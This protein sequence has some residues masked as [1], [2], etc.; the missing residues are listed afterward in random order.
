MQPFIKLLISVIVVIVF[1][2]LNVWGIQILRFVWSSQIDTK[3]TFWRSMKRFISLPKVSE[4]IVVRDP[5]KIYQNGKEVG[6]VVGQVK[7]E[8]T[9]I[10]FEMLTQTIDL[11]ENLPF[12]YR[13]DRLRIK[14]VKKRVGRHIGSTVSKDGKMITQEYRDVME[15]VTC[16]V[17]Q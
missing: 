2:L 16:Q 6:D 7:I 12:E 5:N 15:D 8:D 17:L 13:K 9:F 14:S 3:E 11:K 4:V 10:V 1:L